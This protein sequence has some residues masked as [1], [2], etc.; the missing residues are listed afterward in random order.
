MQIIRREVVLCAVL[1]GISGLGFS[2]LGVKELAGTAKIGDPVS[3]REIYVNTCIRCHGIDGK[4][5]FGIKLVPPPA[6]LTSLAVQSRLD[7]TLFRR[8]HEGKPNTAMGAWKHSLSDEEIWDVL[9]Y[10]RT[11][12]VESGGRP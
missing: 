8:I 11:Y 12:G 2:N 3:G 10:V 4:G 6:D 9:A 5:A 7:G 1:A